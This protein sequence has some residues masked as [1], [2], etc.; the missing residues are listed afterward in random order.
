MRSLLTQQNT[1][2]TSPPPPF[3]PLHH[4]PLTTLSQ[5]FELNETQAFKIVT[6]RGSSEPLFLRT[7]LYALQLGVEMSDVSID[8]QLDY[9]LAAESPDALISQILDQCASYIEKIHPS[10]HSKSIL[11]ATLSV[12]YVSRSGLTDEE[13]WGSVQQ[14]LGCELN[15]EQKECIR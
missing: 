15:N 4:S 12:L 8:E 9:Y 10:M 3:S 1:H 6:A 13:I 11:G 7:V 2:S 5:S 14:L